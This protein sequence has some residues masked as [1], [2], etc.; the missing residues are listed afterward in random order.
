MSIDDAEHA[1]LQRFTEAVQ[2]SPHNLVSKRARDELWTRHVPECIAFT[3]LLPVG[4]QR[5]L[6]VG[7]GGGFPGIV[8]AVLR[9]DLE[10]H[11]LDSVG[12][13]TSFLRDQADALD[14]DVTVHTGRAEDLGADPD[15]TASFGLITAR[16]VAPLQRLV[17][18]TAPFLA[19]GG[20]LYAIKG[21]RWE[22]ELQEASAVIE[23]FGLVATPPA[24]D[25]GTSTG[26]VPL[27]VRL[28]RPMTVAGERPGRPRK[29]SDE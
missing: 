15:L 11:L 22:E 24:F 2:A 16:A 28:H 3:R 12:K 14:L 17:P 7:S 19:P 20:A 4:A 18:W 1:K 6:D 23:R 9:P 10:V 21:A 13:K 26:E 8:I 5:L 25:V 27:V 29:A